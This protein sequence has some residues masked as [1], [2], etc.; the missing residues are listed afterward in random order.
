M[1]G[2]YHQMMTIKLFFAVAMVIN[3]FAVILNEDRKTFQMVS[4]I[5][6]FLLFVIIVSERAFF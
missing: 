6:A 4:A 1:K 3:F 2:R 5:V